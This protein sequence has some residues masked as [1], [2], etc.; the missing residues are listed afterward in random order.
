MRKRRSMMQTDES[1][2][3]FWPAFTDLTST[4][5]LILFVLVLLAF[6]QNLLNGKNM[7]HIRTQ[8]DDS[9]AKLHTADAEISSSEKKLRMLEDNVAKTKAEIEAGQIQLK[10]SEDK[11]ETQ[12]EII[13]ESNRELGNLRSKLQGI[14]VLRVEVLR[15]VKRSIEAELKQQ[16]GGASPQVLIAENGNIVINENLVFEYNSYKIKEQGKSLLKTLSKAF[17]NV[18][19]DEDIR[20]SIDVILVQGHTDERGSVPYNRE[21]SAKRSNAVL[22]YMFEAE[23]SLGQSF[24]EYFA[25][26]AYSEF[27]PVRLEK[28]EAA[29]EQNRRIEISVVLKDSSIQKVIDEYMQGLDPIFNDATGTE[30]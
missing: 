5:A 11:V 22:N 7:Q 2:E 26:S 17:A 29:F 15:K 14:A 23:K 21:L 9:L 1:E 10:M 4:I 6:L 20:A 3:N 19:S 12:R 13:A 24:G 16:S 27:R 25:S 28:T 8:L 30:N 18:L